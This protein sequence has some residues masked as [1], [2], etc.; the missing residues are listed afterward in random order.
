MNTQI[1]I[2]K[3]YLND[4]FKLKKKRFLV[5]VLVHILL[6]RFQPTRDLD[7]AFAVLPLRGKISWLHGNFEGKLHCQCN[8]VN[9]SCA[10][11]RVLKE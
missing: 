1:T 9:F 7:G 2:V 5:R 4:N 8:M 6:W 10:A 11:R 3:K